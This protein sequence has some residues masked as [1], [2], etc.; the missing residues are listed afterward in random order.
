MGLIMESVI[1][2]IPNCRNKALVTSIFCKGHEKADKSL[3]I[4]QEEINRKKKEKS[5]YDK[6]YRTKNK[7]KIKQ[8]KKVYEKSPEGRAMQKRNRNKFKELHL[9]YCRTPEYKAWKKQYDHEFRLKKNYGEYWSAASVLIKLNGILPSKE[10]KYNQGIINKSQKRKK[11]WQRK[12]R[13]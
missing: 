9:E 7:D 12:K 4:I 8:R 6:A 3:F 1:C 2:D 10:I 5:E 13:N 11:Q